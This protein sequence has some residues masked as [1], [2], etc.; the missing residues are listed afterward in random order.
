M[1][2]DELALRLAIAY[3]DD[4]PIDGLRSYCTLG[5]SVAPLER[6]GGSFRQE[7]MF[8]TH[9]DIDRRTIAN[10]LGSFAEDITFAARPFWSPAAP[11]CLRT[12]NRLSIS[13][14]WSPFTTTRPSSPAP[15]FRA[16]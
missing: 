14:G 9:D 15:R 2:D 10:F 13:G 7:L 8:V 16:V 5:L 12:P 1:I 11:R 6:D 3:F 4:R